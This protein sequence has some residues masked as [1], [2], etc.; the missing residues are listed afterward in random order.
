MTEKESSLAV[1]EGLQI[2]KEWDKEYE[3]WW[4]SIVDVVAVLTEQET[5]RGASNYWRKLKQRLIGEGNQLV[6]NCHQLKLTSDD[7]KKYLTDVADLEQM[8]RIIQSIPSK[9]AEPVKQW[10]AKVGSERI[11]EMINPELSI[12]RMIDNYR[13]LGYTE[14]W[15]NQRIKTIEIRKDLTDE[16]HRGGVEEGK[17]YAILTD[18]MT[19][20]WSG[21]SVK[22][23]KDHKNLKKENLRDNMSNAELLINALAELSATEISKVKNPYGFKDNV[24][25]AKEGAEVAKIAR[26]QLEQRTGKPVVS[27]V[28]A[29]DKKRLTYSGDGG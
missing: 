25:V 8:L 19:K 10:L 18:I 14:E 3:K 24:D 9:K 1:F 21:K 12:E 2:R 13:R 4:F 28:N 23:Y 26:M 27:K 5:S 6:T 29:K 16:W 7:G 17:E 22:E 15:I 11:D 20:T